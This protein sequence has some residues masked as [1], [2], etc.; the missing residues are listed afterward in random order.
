MARTGKRALEALRELILAG[1]FHPGARLQPGQISELLETSTTV[2]RESLT[3]L[4]AEGLVTQRPQRGFTVRELNA[5]E[6]EDVTELRCAVEVLGGRLAIERGDLAWEAALIAAHHRL[7]RTARRGDDGELSAE[8]EDAH[9]AFH[10]VL[11]DGAE[12]RPVSEH[13]EALARTTQL[14]LRWAAASPAAGVRDVEAEHQELLDAAL[15]R[16]AARLAEALHQHFRRTA[17]VVLRA[18]IVAPGPVAPSAR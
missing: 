4:V 16:D 17:D 9:R 1:H 18:G 10:R 3:K 14:Y 13:S 7:A 2:V 8:W 12:C 5:C 11:I 15:A 6:L